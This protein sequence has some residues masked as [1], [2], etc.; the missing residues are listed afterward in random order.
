MQTITK[1][2]LTAMLIVV[3]TLYA[4]LKLT[5]LLDKK[6]PLIAET[7]ETNF[8][9][10]NTRINMNEIGF[11]MAFSVEGFL[12]S[13]IKDDPRYVR[14]FARMYYKTEGV[15]SQQVL[16]LHKCTQQDWNQFPEPAKGMEDQID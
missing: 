16:S 1:G 13:K 11:K 15:K 9:D 7:K 4:V 10:F 3:F 5:H 14:L 12:D 6:N 8:Y 2:I